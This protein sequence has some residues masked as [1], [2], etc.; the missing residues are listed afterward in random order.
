MT[1][2]RL[3]EVAKIWN[4]AVNAGEIPQDAVRAAF[5]DRTQR[6]TQR[7]V[8]DAGEAGLLT[9]WHRAWRNGSRLQAVA[10]EIGIE[11][12]KLAQAVLR[13]VPNGRLHVHEYDARIASVPEDFP[14]AFGDMIREARSKRD[15]SQKELAAKVGAALGREVPP[16]AITRTEAG[17]RP[18]PLAELAAFAAVLNLSIDDLIKTQVGASAEEVV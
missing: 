13:H 7:W 16:L 17:T 3:I 11:R 8:R 9:A 12:H 18:V 1:S 4:A 2:D 5:P 10:D 6:T 15:W 14:S